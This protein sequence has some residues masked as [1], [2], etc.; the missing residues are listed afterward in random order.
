MSLGK[1]KKEPPLE[2]LEDVFKCFASELESS[3]YM[4]VLLVE[5]GQA[6]LIEFP[7]QVKRYAE[8]CYIKY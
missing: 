1:Y 7:F 8:N 3:G 6:Q 5:S 4:I 2:S